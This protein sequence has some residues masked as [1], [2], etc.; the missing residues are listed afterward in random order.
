M[1]YLMKVPTPAQN[2]KMLKHHV[3]KIKSNLINRVQS[4]L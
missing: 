4:L 1:S 2:M 3:I